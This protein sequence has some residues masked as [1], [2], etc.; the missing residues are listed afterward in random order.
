[1][2]FFCIGLG[3]YIVEDLHKPTKGNTGEAGKIKDY[4]GISLSEVINYGVGFYRK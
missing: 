3:Y 1:M 4:T 2:N